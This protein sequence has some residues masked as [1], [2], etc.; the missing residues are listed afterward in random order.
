MET[1][2]MCGFSCTE[3]PYECEISPHKAHGK[4]CHIFIPLCSQAHTEQSA[5]NDILSYL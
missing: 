3:V 4:R 2:R 1:V 5:A